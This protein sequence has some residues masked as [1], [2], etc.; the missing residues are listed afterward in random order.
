MPLKCATVGDG[1]MELWDEA[2]KA[3]GSSKDGVRLLGRGQKAL[4]PSARRSRE[5][6]PAPQG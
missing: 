5:C 4:S 1:L 3:E 6:C 2:L